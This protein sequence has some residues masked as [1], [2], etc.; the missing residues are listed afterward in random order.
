MGLGDLGA[1]RRDLGPLVGEL[2]RQGCTFTIMGGPTAT[3]ELVVRLLFPE[4]EY[5]E[6]VCRRLLDGHGRAAAS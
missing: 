1:A 4:D 2:E 3:G 5:R 6:K